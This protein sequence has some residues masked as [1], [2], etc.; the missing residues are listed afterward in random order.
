[1]AFPKENQSASPHLPFT[2]HSAF[3]NQPTY[4]HLKIKSAETHFHQTVNPSATTIMHSALCILHLKTFPYNAKKA[5]TTVTRTR[6]FI[7]N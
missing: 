6:T 1:L 5:G 3:Y 4:R 7:I 2:P